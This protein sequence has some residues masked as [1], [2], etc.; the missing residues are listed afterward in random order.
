MHPTIYLSKTVYPTLEF[1]N[2]FYIKENLKN[3]DKPKYKKKQLLNRIDLR[4]NEMYCGQVIEAERNEIKN[5]GVHGYAKISDW[6]K[7]PDQVY[8][9]MMHMTDIGTWKWI[10]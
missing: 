5:F 1:V 3:K 10:L 6:I 4:T 9:G 8:Y 2:D 7:I